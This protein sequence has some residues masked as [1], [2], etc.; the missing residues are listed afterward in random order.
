MAKPGLRLQRFHRAKPNEPFSA[1]SLRNSWNLWPK[2]GNSQQMYNKNYNVAKTPTLVVPD[3]LS[4]LPRDAEQ[5]ETVGQVN[6]AHTTAPNLLQVKTIANLGTM[7]SITDENTRVFDKLSYMVNLSGRT[8]GYAQLWYFFLAKGPSTVTLTT[9]NADPT[10]GVKTAVEAALSGG[11][12][13]TY[14]RTILVKPRRDGATL[15]YTEDQ[16]DIDLTDQINK[17]ISESESALAQ[18]RSQPTLYFGVATTAAAS[19]SSYVN[20]LKVYAYHT[21]K[22][23][24]IV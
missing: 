3:S 4:A 19:T 21:R 2:K 23:H 20:L 11:S 7:L 18:G 22:R 8:D 5:Y 14:L 16:F 17:F 1:D 24:L 6:L 10:A 12:K 9:T 13:I 15:L